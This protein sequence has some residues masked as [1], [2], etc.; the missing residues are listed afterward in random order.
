MAIEDALWIRQKAM[1]HQQW[2]EESIPLIASENVM[3]PLAKEMVITDL[4]NRYAEGLP[5]HRYYQGNKIYDEI[6][7]KTEELAKKLFNSPQAD[8]RPISGTNANQ[9]VIFA[10]TS[11]GDKIMAP[12]LDSGAHI[13]SAEFG[14][15]GF[16]GLTPVNMEFNTELME[17]DVDKTRKKI[18][19]EKPKVCL[20]GFSV[21]LF[22]AP[23][24]ELKDAMD[25]VSCKVW[26]DGAH[27]LGLIAG[28][29]F[30]DPLREGAHV[31]T[32]STHKTFPGPQ[33]GIILGNT[34]D[35][36]WK[37]VRRGVFP[38]VLSNHHLGNVAALGVTTAEMLEFG[39]AYAENI[40][41]NAQKLAQ[42][43]HELGFKVLAERNG[44]TKSHTILVNVA[45]K[46]G[47][48]YVAEKLEANNIILN[49][50]MIPGD[51]NKKSQDPSG[52][53]IGTQEVTRLGMGK[54]EMVYIAEL[55][56]KALKGKDVK[57]EVKELKSQFNKVKYCYGDHKAYEYIRLF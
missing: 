4:N 37:L 30:Q 17:I 19:N 35:E 43:L 49:K 44:F 38:G 32:G 47:G 23:I 34:S 40:I 12:S 56:D 26:Y 11:P 27:V 41:Q 7:I 13:S 18:L 10:F 39:E 3:S 22:P 1:E 9:A 15:V 5:H 28:K 8:V 29:R 6:E 21:F 31:I 36:D 16:R 53:R 51:S 14:A 25:E 46:G 42:S 24:R 45:D 33:H 54:N 2:F 57:D 55:I 52:I 50:N 20:F 48:K